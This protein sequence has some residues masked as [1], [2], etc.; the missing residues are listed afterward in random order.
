MVGRIALLGRHLRTRE[1]ECPVYPVLTYEAWPV[2]SRVIFFGNRTPRPHQY[3]ASSSIQYIVV[4]LEK[5][6][7]VPFGGRR[8]SHQT[9]INCKLSG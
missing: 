6:A 2:G 5:K 4:A 1:P 7:A 3:A 8:L 9:S